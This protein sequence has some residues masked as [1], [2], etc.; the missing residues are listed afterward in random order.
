MIS[1]ILFFCLPGIIWLLLFFIMW[2]LYNCYCVR[3]LLEIW[4]QK[5]FSAMYLQSTQSRKFLQKSNLNEIIQITT[6]YSFASLRVLNWLYN[7]WI[8]PLTLF[9][10]DFDNTNKFYTLLWSGHRIRFGFG[11]W[12][13]MP[14]STLF[15]L[16]HDGDRS[17]NVPGENHWP[18]ASH[19]LYHIML[20]R[21]HL[22]M[23]GVRT[24]DFSGDRHWLH[25]CQVVVTPTIIRS[26]PVNATS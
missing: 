9:I 22:D 24:H 21:V 1:C 4:L 19:K 2:L 23:K 26:W 5:K 8:Q 20:Y 18:A 6:V 13:L 17:T 14:L 3:N 11:L 25:R 16:Y 7:W 10:L 12:Y 15:Q